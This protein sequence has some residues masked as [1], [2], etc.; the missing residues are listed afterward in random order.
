MEQPNNKDNNPATRT[1]TSIAAD[2]GLTGAFAVITVTIDNNTNTVIPGT[3]HITI[4]DLITKERSKTSAVK[5]QLD[6]RACF[7]LLSE[8]L[9]Q[10]A[11]AHSDHYLYTVEQVATRTG[12]GVVSQG[13]LMHSFGTLET[14]CDIHASLNPAPNFVQLIRPQTWKPVVSLSGKDVEKAESVTK[15]KSLFPSLFAE[16]NAT[17]HLK[18]HNNRADALLI[19]VVALMS[20]EKAVRDYL[21]PS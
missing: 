2:P 14:I 21:L 12:Q 20:K 4:R 16:K 19:A 6:A 11:H 15:C 13:S 8:I 1:I 18:K 5:K 3:T 10:P 7:A 17:L 9:E